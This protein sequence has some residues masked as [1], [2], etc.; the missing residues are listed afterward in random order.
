MGWGVD[1]MRF[2]WAGSER[3]VVRVDIAWVWG[4]GGRCVVLRAL[5]VVVTTDLIGVMVFKQVQVVFEG[6]VDV[7][8]GLVA[9]W[10]GRDG[11]K[12]AVG[13]HA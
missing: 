10:R 7:D 3:L 5:L 2:A 13:G 4:S 8:D 1:G 9:E 6:V 11:I 12:A